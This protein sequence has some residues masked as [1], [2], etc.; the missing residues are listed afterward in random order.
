MKKL[1]S[2]ICTLLIILIPACSQGDTWETSKIRVVASFHPMAQLTEIIGGDKV[3][4]HTIIPAKGDPHSFEPTISDLKKL[5]TADIFIYNGLGLETWLDKALAAAQNPDLVSV[6]ASRGCLPLITESG[7]ADPHLWISLTGSILQ[8]ENI[9][10]ALAA[11]FPDNKDYF[12]QN[13]SEFK[14]KMEELLT[15]YAEKIEKAE[16]R[17]FVTSHA[18][19]GYLCRD[20]DLE[21]NSVEDVFA[22]GEPSAKKLAELVSYCKT[23]NIKTIFVEEAVSPKVAETLAREVG[24]EVKPIYTMATKSDKGYI[25]CMEHNLKSISESLTK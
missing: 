24:A 18:A 19:F 3:E 7:A 4:V 20:L 2:I 13:Y 1:F 17:R 16:N 11:S 15:R 6:E 5:K 8:V 14:E 23:H 25:E 21:Q 10:R 12:E 22:H 9:K